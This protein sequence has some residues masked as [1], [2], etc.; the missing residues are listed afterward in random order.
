MKIELSEKTQIEYIHVYIGNEQTHAKLDFT[1]CSEELLQT[2]LYQA[3]KSGE[4]KSFHCDP[5]PRDYIAEFKELNQIA[6]QQEKAVDELRAEVEPLRS[7]L[8]DAKESAEQHVS[9]L[10]KSKAQVEKLEKEVE[11]LKVKLARYEPK[12]Q[13]PAVE[14]TAKTS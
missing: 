10:K 13:P 1:K 8:Q 5:P 2:I 14:A 9:D 11:T 12:D 7:Q 4:G 3:N 6:E